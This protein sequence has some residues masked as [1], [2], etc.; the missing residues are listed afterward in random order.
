MVAFEKIQYR[1]ADGKTPADYL[2]EL[3]INGIDVMKLAT[4]ISQIPNEGTLKG[5]AL[6]KTRTPSIGIWVLSQGK[7]HLYYSYFKA[8]NEVCFLYLLHG[9]KPQKGLSEALS[10]VKQVYF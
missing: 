1:D 8:R 10:R 3:L 7:Y 9:A 4:F 6:K 5:S 2:C